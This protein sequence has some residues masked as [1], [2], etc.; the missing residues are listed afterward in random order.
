MSKYMELETWRKIFDLILKNPGLD[1]TQIAEELNMSISYVENCLRIMQENGEITASQEG[2]FVR[3]Y[4]GKGTLESNGDRRTDDTRIR[5]YITISKNPGLHLSRIAETL[6]MSA[7]LAEYHLSYMEKR[8]F[9]ISIKDE[10]GYFKRYYIRDSDV[11]VKEKK[12]L[13]LLRQKILLRI[14]VQSCL[15]DPY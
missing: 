2:E 7:S 9:I 8:D 3:Y 14:G 15:F 6:N 11:G 1:S 4:V 13:A 12:I 5:I 10:K